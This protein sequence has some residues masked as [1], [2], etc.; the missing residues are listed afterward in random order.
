MNYFLALVKDV[1]NIISEEKTNSLRS[2]F[3]TFF[4]RNRNIVGEIKP[5]TIFLWKTNMW[6]SGGFPIFKF[7][8]NEPLIGVPKE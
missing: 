3:L 5:N 4:N 2:H 1:I 6:I 8:F 7:E